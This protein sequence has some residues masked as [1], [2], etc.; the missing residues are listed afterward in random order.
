MPPQRGARSPGQPA[1]GAP[2]GI[3]RR[4]GHEEPGDRHERQPETG[5]HDGG[6]VDH[7]HDEGRGAEEVDAPRAGAGGTRA[8]RRRPAST[9]AR[10]VLTAKPESAL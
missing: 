1:R 6:R 9:S 5:G 10:T 7:E 2:D 4:R 8:R 3:P